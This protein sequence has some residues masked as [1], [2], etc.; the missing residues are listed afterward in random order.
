MY[1]RRKERN[2]FV[3]LILICARML[4]LRA[5]L[6]CSTNLELLTIILD[7]VV[8]K[9]KSAPRLQQLQRYDSFAK[10]NALI[11]TTS[12]LKLHISNIPQ[13]K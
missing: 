13:A 5:A 8:K 1:D 10:A 7:T 3:L 9:I 6:S 4:V 11:H 2:V 12:S